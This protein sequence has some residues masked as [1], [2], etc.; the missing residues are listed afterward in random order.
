MADTLVA[1]FI[2]LAMI[3]IDNTDTNKRYIIVCTAMLGCCLWAKNEGIVLTILFFLFYGKELLLKGAY[4]YSVIG[5]GLP[6]VM[7]AIFKIGFAPQ[8]DIIE[9]QG[10]TTLSLFTQPERYKIIYTAWKD[11]I[12]AHY[13]T[14]AC[15]VTLCILLAIVRGKL[16]DRRILFIL[17]V[18][19]AYSLV[20]L[21]TPHD[22]GWHLKTSIDRLIHQ[23]MP[24][25]VYTVLMYLTNVSFFNFRAR[26]GAGQQSPA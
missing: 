23:L 15:V 7:Y 16:P 25:S 3:A 12:N 8:N 5:I 1:F 10:K 6:I 17:S 4:R 9:S 26:F 11:S 24:V 19:V 13:Y 18:C 22:L 2:L 21:I 20:Y 14:I